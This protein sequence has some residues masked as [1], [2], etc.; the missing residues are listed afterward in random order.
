MPEPA[1][2]LNDIGSGAIAAEQ[3]GGPNGELFRAHGLNSVDR[4]N[5]VFNERT[6]ALIQNQGGIMMS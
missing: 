4:P 6:P 1:P 3:S 5:P 2:G